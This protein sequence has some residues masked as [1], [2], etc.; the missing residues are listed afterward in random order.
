MKKY[1]YLIL[2]IIITL[3]F[4]LYQQDKRQQPQNLQAVY[5]PSKALKPIA[6]DDAVRTWYLGEM[7]IDIPEPMTQ[8]GDFIIRIYPI[9]SNE[10]MVITFYEKKPYQS[11]KEI[12]N[13]PFQKPIPRR[14]TLL[15]GWNAKF[16]TSDDVSEALRRPSKLNTFWGNNKLPLNSA[17]LGFDA[18]VQEDYGILEFSYTEHVTNFS[19]YDNPDEFI[20]NRKSTFTCWLA[21]FFTVYHWIG[22]NQHPGSNNIATQ[23][24]YM[25]I[26]DEV[27]KYNIEISTLFCLR[28]D[29]NLD[30]LLKS[31]VIYDIFVTTT[32]YSNYIQKDN[33]FRNDFNNFSKEGILSVLKDEEELFDAVNYEKLKIKTTTNLRIDKVYIESMQYIEALYQ[34]IWQSARSIN[35]NKLSRHSAPSLLSSDPSYN[36]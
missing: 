23:F 15:H 1:I 8:I 35:G 33:W 3:L 32:I 9:P 18:F 17:T 11:F 6:L 34:G 7:S 5:Q 36:N 27:K 20:R 2:F 13:S 25:K 10:E 24:G 28:N 4:V 30:K 22:K 26:T 14:E 16:Q 31:E 19:D 29:L 21:N 12:S